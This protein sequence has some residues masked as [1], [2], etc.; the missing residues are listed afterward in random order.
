LQAGVE[1]GLVIRGAEPEEALFL[2]DG[3]TL[4]DPRNNQ[5]ITGV[6]L[7]AIQEVSLERGGFNAEYGQVRSGLI[8]VVTRE[9]SRNTYGASFTVRYS[10]P[11]QKHFGVSPYDENSMWLRPY[12]DPEVAFVGTQNGSWDEWTQRQYPSFDGW[13]IT[14]ERL[15]TDGDPDNDI[16]PAGL[17]QLFRWQ[18]RRQEITDQPD[19]NIDAGLGGPI[20]LVSKSLGDLRFFGALRYNE[21]M[22]VVPLSR[23]DHS[24]YDGLLKITSDVGAQSKLT[25]TAFL[26]KSFNVA[27]N[28]TEQASSTDYIRSP[29]EVTENINLQPFTSSSRVFSDSYYSVAEVNYWAGSADYRQILSASTFVEASAE[30][31]ERSYETGPTELRDTSDL[32]EI[33]PGA[34]A[35]PAPFGWSP[36][37]DVGVGDGILFGGHTSTS[38]DTSETRATRVKVSMTSQV[39]FHNQVKAGL[40]FAQTNLDLNYGIVNLVFPESNTQVRESWNPFTVSAFVQDKIEF[41]GLIANLGVRA[42]YGKGNTDWVR[43]HAF[44]KSYYSSNY[45]PDAEFETEPAK[46]KLQ[47][48]PRLGISH[49]VTES[50]KLFFN[51]GHFN[52]SPSYELMFSLARGAADEMKTYGDPDLAFAQTISYELGYD[53]SLFRDYLLQ[54]AGFYHDITNQV[55]FT[56]FRSADGSITYNAAT[57]QSYEDIRGFELTVKKPSGRWFSGLASYT[58]MVATAGRFG[59]DEVYEDPAEQRR[60]DTD[61]GNFAQD[62]PKA[63]PRGNLILSLHTPDDFRSSWI[64]RD[65]LGGWTATLVGN[66]RAGWY[67][68]WNPLQVAGVS[69]NLQVED[70]WNLN[71]RIDKTFR[72][73]Y[74]D[75]TL[76]LDVDNL[77]DT[78]RLNLSS[79][80]DVND[81]ID[82]FDSL[83]LPES[84]AYRN[85]AGDD[86]AGAFR[87][88]DVEFQPIVLVAAVD[89]ITDPHERPIYYERSTGRYMEFADE[90]WSEISDSRLN[91]VLDTKAY[92]DMPNQSSFN[93]L[94]PR[95]VFFGVRTSF[96]L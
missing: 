51:Y 42:D 18:H 81:Q 76:L 57:S 62:R 49:P 48:S 89:Q 7:S 29:E 2:V 82:Y 28:G 94:N 13:N 15:L 80:F 4:R 36:L 25:L 47:V 83:H 66:Y 6:P 85:I 34:F 8:N 65:L 1:S 54:L 50:S 74:A 53:Q 77:L 69:Q 93:F 30:H 90:A 40:E 38:R 3:V 24:E 10:P 71:L 27:V 56:T 63:E 35:D 46:G 75:V 9:G 22:L 39:D 70:Y 12:T 87:D 61:I 23:D 55:A 33:Y 14:S 44:D 26:G 16:T 86:R 5:P 79:F 43:T 59:R 37:P 91:E 60:F 20:P 67:T 84:S 78:K 19:Y 95:R 45:D 21:E 68:T 64:G 52:Q 32:T 11:D 96:N 88:P 92:I 17:E 31:F 72:L 73:G 58:Y 41:K